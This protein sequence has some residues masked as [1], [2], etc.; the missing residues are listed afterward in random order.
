LLIK[1]LD[2][3]LFFRWFFGLTMNDAVWLKV[4]GVS[5]TDMCRSLIAYRRLR[6]FKQASNPVFP[7]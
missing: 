6:R 3:N 4:G 5:V 1:Q 7:G 2:Y